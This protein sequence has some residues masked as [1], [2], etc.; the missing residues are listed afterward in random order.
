M[1]NV[2]QERR[3]Y[4]YQGRNNTHKHVMP[5]SDFRWCRGGSHRMCGVAYAPVNRV[6]F[7]ADF[8]RVQDA[9]AAASLDWSNRFFS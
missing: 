2:R 9:P 8:C 3:Q 1:V 6:K 7:R 5:A 4:G